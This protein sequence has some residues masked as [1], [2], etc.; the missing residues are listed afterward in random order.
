MAHLTRVHRRYYM[1]A[2]L[3]ECLKQPLKGNI[4]GISGITGFY[5][6]ID[7]YSSSLTEVNYPAVDMQNM[8][9]KDDSFDFVIS[10]QVI[11]HLA[12]PRTAI[13]E[14]YRVLRKDGIGIYPNV[15]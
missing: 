11:E 13:R 5:H 2:R 15:P 10:D 14:S 1:Y 3:R 4:L 7:I 12:D 8:P 9:F 6:I